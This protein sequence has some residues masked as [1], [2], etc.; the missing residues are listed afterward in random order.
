MTLPFTLEQGMGFLLFLGAIIGAGAFVAAHITRAAL[1]AWKGL[2]EARGQENEQLKA[3]VTRLENRVLTLEEQI[4][5]L[6]KQI[7]PGRIGKKPTIPADL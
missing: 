3:K 6:L 4:E 7:T 5:A 1:E 2:A